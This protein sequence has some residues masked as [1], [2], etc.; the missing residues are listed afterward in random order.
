MIGLLGGATAKNIQLMDAYCDL[1]VTSQ[2][3]ITVL[4]KNIGTA[5][6]T[7]V[8]SFIDGKTANPTCTVNFGPQDTI[9]CEFNKIDTANIGSGL[10]QLRIVSS[11]AVGGPVTC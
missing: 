3:N 2:Y 11:T 7:T 10:H 6:I 9:T 8:N 5:N 1:V 4:I